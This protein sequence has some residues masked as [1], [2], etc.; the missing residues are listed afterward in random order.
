[1][2]FSIFRQF[3]AA[4]IRASGE[5]VLLSHPIFFNRMEPNTALNIVRNPLRKLPVLFLLSGVLAASLIFLRI[6]AGRETRLFENLKN[7]VDAAAGP[8]ASPDATVIEAMHLTRAITSSAMGHNSWIT[9]NNDTKTL[10]RLLRCYDYP[11]R[12]GQMK[13]KGELPAHKI[14]EVFIDGRWLIADPL[15]NKVFT[16]PNAYEG[17]LYT[18]TPLLDEYDLYFYIALVVFILLNAYIYVGTRGLLPWQTAADMGNF[19]SGVLLEQS[20]QSGVII[21]Q[22]IP[23]RVFL[24]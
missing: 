9:F 18:Q 16:R 15:N 1:V 8:N 2:P 12:I 23:S 11:V 22:S 10:A 7:M 17:I 4:G 13:A 19:H 5:S 3:N 14:I 6:Q 20:Q 24:N 21:G